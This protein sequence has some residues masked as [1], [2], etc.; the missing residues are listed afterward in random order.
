MPL[1]RG[2][3]REVISH[4]ISTLMHEGYPQNQ[5]VAIAL[6][7]AGESPRKKKAMAAKKHHKKGH[8]RCVRVNEKG[9]FSKNGKH[10]KCFHVK[11]ARKS[12]RK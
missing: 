4:N 2:K 6:H 12:R 5:A 11:K 10:R 9:Q 3:S 7:T 1:R 8:K